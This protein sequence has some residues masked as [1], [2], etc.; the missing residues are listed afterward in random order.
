MTN[1]YVNSIK[2]VFVKDVK[3]ELRTRYAISSFFLFV[4]TT[5]SILV[6]STAGVDFD[7]SVAAGLIWVIMFFGAMT[8]L[9]RSFI[10]EEER[11]TV[12]QLKLSS[13]ST[14]VFF[15]KLVFNSILS[16]FLNSFAVV[17]FYLMFNKI[18]LNSTGLFAVSYLL[19]SIGIA[20]ASTII[21]AIIA[22]ANTKGAL[23][24]I[25]SFPIL[26]PLMLFG[27]ESTRMAMDGATFTQ[28]QNNFQLMIAYSG[29][30]IV[31]SYILFDFLWKE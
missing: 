9:G 7:T 1:I 11:G 2:A 4:V 23:F 12:L 13:S 24:P 16:V 30:V 27:I 10:S 18:K 14:G 3:S 20:A 8:G 26:L 15:G 28:V 5:I 17:L 19:G 6:F 21:S 29:I 31:V 25:L 22:K